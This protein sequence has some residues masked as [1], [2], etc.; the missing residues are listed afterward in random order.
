[1]E[2]KH[3]IHKEFQYLDVM[4]KETVAMYSLITF[5]NGDKKHVEYLNNVLAIPMA[6][7]I[8]LHS[9]L[10]KNSQLRKII[11]QDI[12]FCFSA[13]HILNDVFSGMCR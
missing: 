11:F 8:T 4:R 2:R 13:I 10:G 5:R 3:S 12:H 6:P 1:M 9:Q 7:C